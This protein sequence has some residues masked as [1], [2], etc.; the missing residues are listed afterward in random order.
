MAND[1]LAIFC[2]TNFIPLYS[3]RIRKKARH[4]N[5]VEIDEKYLLLQE[6]ELLNLCRLRSLIEFVEHRDVNCIFSS[7][8]YELASEHILHPVVLVLYDTVALAI[9]D[10]GSVQV[11][12]QGSELDSSCPK[13]LKGLICVEYAP[14]AI[15]I[16]GVSIFWSTQSSAN[17]TITPSVSSAHME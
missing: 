16:L 11:S 1:I 13:T 10:S 15:D 9:S 2:V 8:L 6:N 17:L 14:K 12:V 5:L 4:D 7:K 3:N